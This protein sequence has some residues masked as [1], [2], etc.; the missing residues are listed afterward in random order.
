MN[1]Q[2][3][4]ALTAI[5]LAGKRIEAGQPV[6]GLTE[7]QADQLLS[8]N[9][10]AMAEPAEPAPPL[11]ADLLLLPADDFEREVA[12]LKLDEL[13]DLAAALELDV[14]AAKT[15]AEFT[16]LLNLARARAQGAQ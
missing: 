3:Y 6:E 13:K 8:N 4:V 15:K 9:S 16:E 14:C 10:I 5:G 12:K 2:T 1:P 11:P 7:R